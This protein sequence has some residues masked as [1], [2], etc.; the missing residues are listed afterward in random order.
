MRIIHGILPIA[1][2]SAK[3]KHV[4]VT[5]TPALLKREDRVRSS[6]AAAESAPML[7]LPP[8]LAAVT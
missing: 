4:L 5:V 8:S 2:T 6:N 1:E 7:S 3:D